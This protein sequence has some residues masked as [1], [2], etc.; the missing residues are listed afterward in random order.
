MCESHSDG[1]R[2]GSVFSVGSCF[3]CLWSGGQ[4]PRC[5]SP[6]TELATWVWQI[7][8]PHLHVHSDWSEGWSCDKQGQSESVPEICGLD[9]RR[10][11]G[12]SSFGSQAIMI[13]M[14]R[15]RP[16]SLAFAITKGDPGRRKSS[17]YAQN[18]DRQ[19]QEW[20]GPALASMF[21]PWGPAMSL[22][23]HPS[24]KPVQAMC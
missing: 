12:L 1:P 3:L 24:R 8:E 21:E 13:E 18:Q 10:E 16:P 6:A 20:G 15:R 7:R 9:T 11:G 17:Q 23:P 22:E 2:P 19:R 5:T 4:S 14:G